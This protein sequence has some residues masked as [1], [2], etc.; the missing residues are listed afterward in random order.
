MPDKYYVL[1]TG[2]P[3]EYSNAIVVN[4]E[5]GFDSIFRTLE[6]ACDYCADMNN[7]PHPPVVYAPHMNVKD[8]HSNDLTTWVGAHDHR[9]ALISTEHER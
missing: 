2:S 3:S 8:G 9:D 7:E 5:Y 4:T 6:M 1:M